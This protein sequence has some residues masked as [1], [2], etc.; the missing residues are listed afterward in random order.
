MKNKKE[1]ILMLSLFL[2]GAGVLGFCLG[3]YFGADYIKMEQ[4]PIPTRIDF[5]GI[6]FGL[7]S[8]TFTVLGFCLAGYVYISWKQQ[9]KKVNL[10]NIEQ[11]LIDQLLDMTNIFRFYIYGAL[12]EKN[13]SLTDGQ[14]LE[15]M[16]SI[17]AVRKSISKIY[18]YQLSN[19][20]N[21][22][23]TLSDL[24]LDNKGDYLDNARILTRFFASVGDKIE[25]GKLTTVSNTLIF[26]Q[27]MTEDEMKFLEF[28]NT[29]NSVPTLSIL[30]SGINRHFN[31]AIKT[32]NHN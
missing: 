15:L 29:K 7:V 32:I 10:L 4:A 22:N 18:L 21:A 27:A 9:Q 30:I 5:L 3:A 12:V 24:S 14:Y 23:M 16:R 6:L 17:Q 2:I 25:N 13:E 26:R 28:D 20:R 19:D 8:T 1:N 31:E 11:G